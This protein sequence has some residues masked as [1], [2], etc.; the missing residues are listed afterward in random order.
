VPALAA[1]TEELGTL[2]AKG[3]RIDP[4]LTD[5]T[6]DFIGIWSLLLLLLMLLLLVVTVVIASRLTSGKTGDKWVCREVIEAIIPR[7]EWASTG[8]TFEA[9]FV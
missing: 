2:E 9:M 4:I 7:G 5:F 6:L 3:R 8:S 1:V